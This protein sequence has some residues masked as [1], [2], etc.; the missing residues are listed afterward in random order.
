[1]TL[2]PAVLLE[3]LAAFLIGFAQEPAPQKPP[4]KPPDPPKTVDAP[5]VQE[6]PQGEI[7]YPVGRFKRPDGLVSLCYKVGF[8]R[9]RLLKSILATRRRIIS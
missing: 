3:I 9:G 2:V 7:L 1:M 4:E 5:K 6:R 8:Q